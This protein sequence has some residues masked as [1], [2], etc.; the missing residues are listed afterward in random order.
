MRLIY[1]YCEINLWDNRKRGVKKPNRSVVE[2]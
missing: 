2:K 1:V